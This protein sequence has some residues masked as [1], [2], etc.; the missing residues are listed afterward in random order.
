MPSTLNASH[1]VLVCTLHLPAIWASLNVEQ[2]CW[3][4]LCLKNKGMNIKH[5]QV[6]N[7]FLSE[8]ERS[9]GLGKVKT[10]LSLLKWTCSL[11]VSIQY[12]FSCSDST[13]FM[14]W[15][16]IYLRTNAVL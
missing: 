10:R 13:A 14:R 1:S 2:N 9:W 4:L 8:E 5:M 11:E 16:F 3:S 12:L 6:Y 7:P 15:N